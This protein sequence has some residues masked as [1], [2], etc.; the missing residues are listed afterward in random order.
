MAGRLPTFL[1]I[2]AMKSGTSSLREYLRGHPDVWLPPAD[3]LHFFIDAGEWHRGL[4]W[5]RAQFAGAGD[6]I[7]VG[8]KSPTYSMLPEH[9]EVPPRVVAVVPDVRLVYV[10]RH[11]VERLV[12]HW[13]HNVHQGIETQPLARALRA[14]PRYLDTSR[15][16]RQLAAWAD[17]VDRDQ[18]LV[19]TTDQLEADQAATMA[20]VARHLGVIDVTPG[21]VERVHRSADKAVPTATLARLRRLP[22][23]RQAVD[24]LPDSV[25]TL[26][27]RFVRRP[28]STLDTSIDPDTSGWL[29][30]ELEPDVAALTAWLPAPPPWS[31]RSSGSR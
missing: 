29:A 6:A 22:G 20:A 18:L 28:A 21:E 30:D 23:Y 24:A 17:V 2:G 27:R 13:V 4:D 26:G 7:A 15:Y 25:R 8:E 5:Y 9:P 1:I 14:D 12:S 19:I 10:V 31:L 11:P 3:E 16:A